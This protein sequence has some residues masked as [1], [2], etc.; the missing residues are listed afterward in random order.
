MSWN[1]R[2]TFFLIFLLGAAGT[3]SLVT[4]SASGEQLKEIQIRQPIGVPGFPGGNPTVPPGAR[5]G[6]NT[7]L[8]SALKLLVDEDLKGPIEAAHEH[9]QNKDWPKAISW[10][11]KLLRHD[12]NVFAPVYKRTPSGERTRVLVNVRVEANS[13]IRSLPKE[14]LDFYKLEFGPQ[15]ET[16]LKTAKLTGDDEILSQVMTDYLYTDAGVEATELLGTFHLDRGNYTGA[17]L[18][19]ERLFQRESPDRLSSETLLKAAL[20]FQ[21]AGDQKLTDKALEYLKKNG[22]EVRLGVDTV[23]VDDLSV[24]VKKMERFTASYARSDWFQTGG[25][26]A[27]SGQGIGGTAYLMDANWHSKLTKS[28]TVETKLKEAQTKLREKKQPVLPAYHPIAAT[29]TYEEGGQI[30]RQP[31]IIHRN[32]FGVEA[33]TPDGEIWWR[34]EFADWSME[35]MLGGTKSTSAEFAGELNKWLTGH[36]NSSSQPQRIIENSLVGNLSTDNQFVFAIDDFYVPPYLGSQPYQYNSQLQQMHPKVRRAIDYNKLQAYEL[37]SGKL[38]WEV[39]GS[40]TSTIAPQRGKLVDCFFMGAP[41]PMGG[42]LYVL[43]EKKEELFL[44]TLDPKTGKELSRLRMAI[45]EEKMATNIHRRANAA[46]LAYGDGI[47]VCPTNAGGVLGVDLMTRNVIWMYE[48]REN[49]ITTTKPNTGGPF[50]GGGRRIVPPG[51][52]ASSQKFTNISG[53]KNS[54]PVIYGGKLVIAPP[55]GNSVHCINLRDGSP[56]WRM[57]RSPDDLYLGGVFDDK[58]IIVNK[59]NSR[60]LN[61]KDGSLAWD[62]ETGEPSGRG[63]ASDN[64]YYL[65]L[66]AGKHSNR[67]EICAIDIKKGIIQGRT[68]ARDDTTRTVDTDTAVPGNLL[69]YKGQVISQGLFRITS[70]PQLALEIAKIDAQLAKN[71]EDP[72]G[73]LRRGTLRLYRGDLGGAIEDLR[74]AMA[75]GK[76]EKML[77]EKCRERLYDTYT[78]FFQRDFDSAEKWLEEYRAMCNVVRPDTPQ[79]QIAAKQAEERLRLGNYYC[80]LG[81][82]REKQKK[83]VDAYKAYMDFARLGLDNKELM[84]VVDEPYVKTS[85]LVWARGRISA[86]AEQ[87]SAMERAPLEKLIQEQL[88][89]IRKESDLRGLKGFVSLFGSIKGVGQEA[90][91][92]LVDWL[93]QREDSES[94]VEAERHLGILRNQRDNPTL[95]AQAVEKSANLMIKKEMMEDAAFYYQLL[96]TDFADV[97]VRDGLTGKDIYQE[98]LADKRLIAYLDNP[99]PITRSNLINVENINKTQSRNSGYYEFEPKGDHLPF[100][101]RYKLVMQVNGTT[102]KVIDKYTNRDY[103][104]INIT[105]QRYAFQSIHYARGS[106]PQIE[107]HYYFHNLGHLVVLQTGFM[108][109]GID[110]VNKK[111]LWEYNLAEQSI[112]TTYYKSHTIDPLDNSVL[113]FY[114][115]GWKQRLGGSKA[116]SP[117]AVCVQTRS[118]IKALHPVTGKILWSRNDVARL[119]HLYNDN[120]YLYV[121]EV[122]D[123]TL[124]PSRGRVFRVNDGVEVKV[125]DYANYYNQRLKMHG[126]SLLFA[127]ANGKGK[128]LRFYDVIQGKDIWSKDMTEGSHL[129][130]S[131]VKHLTGLIE[132]TGKVTLFDLKKGKEAVV[133]QM[134]PEHL[135]DVRTIRLLEDN[136]SYYLACDGDENSGN[137]YSRMTNLMPNTGMRWVSVNGYVYSL[138]KQ[139]GKRNWYYRPKDHDK[140]TSFNDPIP[141][142]MVLESFKEMPVVVFTTRFYQRNK[143]G[144]NTNATATEIINKKNGKLIFEEKLPMSSVQQ[145]HTIT[146]D[147]REKSVDLISYNR[148]LSLKISEEKN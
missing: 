52:G 4:S 112:T 88:Q 32:W 119:C 26:L 115:D 9:I 82:G 70:Y 81:K 36:M 19:F 75:S 138:D 125:K 61:L 7:E 96:G 126:R 28:A 91:M 139:T 110:P 94:S 69:F 120:E 71:S 18:C 11:Q 60:A 64:I 111:K 40:S 129:V 128:T 147:P 93:S 141:Q 21:R 97:V 85:P 148:T 65:P 20:A 78:D 137:F 76:L 114:R 145:I 66:R 13:M 104:S 29:T 2:R 43:M 59:T 24:W 51:G 56:E 124:T 45:T 53:W 55:D 95:S 67:P 25:N 17:S 136:N 30:H 27:R 46:H 39:G 107:P 74:K 68:I 109:F 122:N 50:P 98:S 34:T 100:F 41:L 140:G 5:P 62:L 84:S 6:S 37:D 72:Q 15:A 146:V 89:D 135:K 14:G 33:K 131:K 118:A 113:V 108:V 42:K 35:R 58:V 86:M 49:G 57:T 83:F 132:K 133:S 99:E 101:R 3:L 92:E 127:Q 116:L 16:M 23:D 102:F 123:E 12:D 1:I 143:G 144:G 48:Y 90:R 73:R 117:K 47:M 31:L 22:D 103:W 130:I 105:S 44:L 38:K 63:V 8:S 142:M 10:L 79:A 77:Q 87:A 80:L 121:I 54:P 106:N 134:K